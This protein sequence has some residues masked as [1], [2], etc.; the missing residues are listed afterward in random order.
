MGTTIK[1]DI[2]IFYSNLWLIPFENMEQ[3]GPKSFSKC[4]LAECFFVLW[5]KFKGSEQ[6]WIEME[7]VS[8]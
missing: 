5:T 7:G 4:M 1:F 8:E 2:S 3:I 6:K